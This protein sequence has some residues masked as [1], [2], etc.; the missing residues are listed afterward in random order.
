MEF[1]H[2]SCETTHHKGHKKSSIH[3]RHSPQTVH[4][5]FRCH[6]CLKM[7]G[8]KE[9]SFG[10]LMYLA[11]CSS[12]YPLFTAS[13][14]ASSMTSWSGAL[15]LFLLTQMCNAFVCSE[16]FVISEPLDP[17]RSSSSSAIVARE[18]CLQTHQEEVSDAL[19]GC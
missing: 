6:L 5:S 15:S 4:I 1:Q 7:M 2:S 3:P 9:H 17:G 12:I 13:T 8:M 16:T 18:T 14:S 10:K 19:V 11:E